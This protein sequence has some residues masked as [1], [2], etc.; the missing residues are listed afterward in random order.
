MR[1]IKFEAV[2]KNKC[3][4]VLTIHFLYGDMISDIV[5]DTEDGPK[6][7]NQYMGEIKIREYTGLKDKNGKEIFEGDIVINEYSS[8]QMVVDEIWFAH[9]LIEIHKMNNSLGDYN[10]IG[11]IYENPE[12]L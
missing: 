5:I 4:S 11:N 6:E 1:E 8:M 3:Y 10:V 7:M 2:Y 9:R 12:L